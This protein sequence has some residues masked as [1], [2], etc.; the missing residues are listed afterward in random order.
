MEKRG[1]QL[2]LLGPLAVRRGGEPVALPAS[3]KVRA[4]LAY[5]ALAPLPV[6]RS[7]LCELLWD[8]PD[9]PRGELRWS[10][11]KLRRILDEPGR[12]RVQTREDTVALDLA[13]CAVDALEVGRAAGDGFAGVPDP[14]L[15][16]LAQ[17]FRGEFSEGLE[18]DRNPAFG[19]WLT[20]QRRRFRACHAALLEQLAR[21]A[22]GAAAFGYLEKWLAPAPLDRP[23]HPALLAALARHG[24]IREG[25]EHVAAAA[26]QFEAEGLDSG[27]M[28]EAWR[29]ARSQA[30]EAPHAAEA[31]RRASIAVMPF[32]DRSSAPAARGGPA[33]ALAHDVITRLAKLRG[34]FV[35]AQGTV[36]ALHERSVGAEEA[37]RM[38]NVEYVVSGSVR[39]RGGGAA[40]RGRAGPNPPA[41]PVRGGNLLHPPP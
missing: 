16:A 27:P 10:L 15:S 13:D 32:V 22:A 40:G 26:R 36:F 25:E 18:I 35:I 41:A 9:D 11:S 8:V 1:M 4:L 12:A 6:P 14:R 39:R 19:G 3:R 17:L 33:D 2:Q 23:A 29:S 31:P 20:A 24:R 34:M 30:A 21:A 28:Y 37:G 7:Q 5:L 38:L